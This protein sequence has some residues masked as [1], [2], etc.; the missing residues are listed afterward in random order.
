[1]G[2]CAVSRR[3]AAFRQAAVSR[4]VRGVLKAGATVARVE[5]DATGK[6]VVHCSDDAPAPAAANP[7][8]WEA[9]LRRAKRW[10]G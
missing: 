9:R 8:E 4:A 3:P 10:D 1:M 6:I 7:E 2:V 5:I